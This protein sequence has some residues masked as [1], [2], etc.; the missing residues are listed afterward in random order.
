MVG[1]ARQRHR[2]EQDRLWDRLHV[3]EPEQ[4]LARVPA[5]L[6]LDRCA[7]RLHG[8][9]LRNP[10]PLP[11]DRLLL[12]LALQRKPRER[13]GER[14]IPRTGRVAEL[15]VVG[16]DVEGQDAALALEDREAVDGHAVEDGLRAA[17][18][19][20]GVPP[21]DPAAA[22]GGEVDLLQR[23]VVDDRGDEDVLPQV[24][25]PRGGEVVGAVGERAHDADVGVV[26]GGARA[27]QVGLELVVEVDEGAVDVDGLVVEHPGAV[28]VVAAVLHQRADG[29]QLGP[30]QEELLGPALRG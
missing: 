24:V 7:H 28:A 18:D 13:D 11:H 15:R 23:D 30:A 19:G 5:D 2:V 29:T 25:V 10:L 9:L 26:G 21:V 22:V 14:Q 8:N 6:H 17:E 4:Q 12:Q 3:G 16:G 1:I 20:G 27:E